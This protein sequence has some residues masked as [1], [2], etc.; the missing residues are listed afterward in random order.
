VNR[1]IA[2][3]GND[4]ERVACA[5]F[6]A[7]PALHM[8]SSGPAADWGLGF[9]QSGDVLL[10]KRLRGHSPNVDF[11]DLAHELR[12]DA[13][14]GRATL[15]D[16]ERVSASNAD[17]FRFRTWLFGAVG[18]FGDFAQ[19]SPDLHNSIPEFLRRNIRG[20]SASEQLFHLFLAFL[21]DAGL[22]ET[23]PAQPE[24]VERALSESVS[25]VNR[26]LAKVGA[27]PARLTVVATNGRCLVA[28]SQGH[29]VQFLD[30]HGIA[31]CQLCQS[32]QSEGKRE[33]PIAHERL[34]AVIV[35]ADHQQ[36]PR[37][38]WQV[39]PDGGALLVGPH[40]KHQ[41]KTAR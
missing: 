40:L 31:N 29:P 24:P 27:A 36:G 6:P 4:P 39:L 15:G 19:I 26:L 3:I 17:P 1:L 33:R 13:L 8:F 37:A 11:Y 20:H 30:V 32:K 28:L 35:E 5:L 38:G 22:L 2:F 41:I 34:R 14:L 12:A 7:R 18:T 9:V 16:S 23:L 21:H 10:Q 25:F